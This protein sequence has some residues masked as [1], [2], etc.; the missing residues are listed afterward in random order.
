MYLATVGLMN[1]TA[2]MRKKQSFSLIFVCVCF[3]F[4]VFF[5][6]NTVNVMALLTNRYL[7]PDMSPGVYHACV[8]SRFQCSKAMFW[9][10]KL[11]QVFCNIA[12]MCFSKPQ[13]F[14]LCFVNNA[15]SFWI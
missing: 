15:E 7:G 13:L 8:E 6:M 10:Q 9:V 3:L 1:R 2:A 14:V 5:W 12:A 11:S 4:F